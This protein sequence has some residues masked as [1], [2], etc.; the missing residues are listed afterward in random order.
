MRW[1]VVCEHK[2]DNVSLSSD[3]DDF[4]DSV[5]CVIKHKGSPEKIEISREVNKEVEELAFKGDTG[6]GLDAN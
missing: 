4:E 5:V 3:E 6:R 2:V 1:L